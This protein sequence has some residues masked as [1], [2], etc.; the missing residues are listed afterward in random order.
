M[1]Q[2]ALL[3]DA[4][5]GVNLKVAECNKEAKALLAEVVPFTKANEEE[6][7]AAD[8]ER[9]LTLSWSLSDA[10]NSL[11]VAKKELDALKR[12]QG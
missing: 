11:A 1:N 5:D 3:L 7:L 9:V 12:R 10:R 8:I 4:L 6:I 2:N